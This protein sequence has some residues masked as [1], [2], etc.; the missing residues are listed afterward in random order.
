M[1]LTLVLVQVAAATTA[2]AAT[3]PAAPAQAEKVCK[4]VPQAGSNLQRKICLTR[5]EWADQTR[6]ARDK[7]DT[8]NRPF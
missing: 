7:V 2:P 4:R 1:L 3:S 8:A 5:E 6:V